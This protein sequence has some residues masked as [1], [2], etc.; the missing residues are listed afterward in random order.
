MIELANYSDL[1]EIAKLAVKARNHMLHGGLKQ[2]TGDYPNVD[3]FLN[4]YHRQGLYIYKE[5]GRIIASISI[6]HENEEAYREISWLKNHSLV[7]HRVL[8]DPE[9]QKQGI[10]LELFN[11]AKAIGVKNKYSSIKVDTHPDNFKMQGLIRKAGYKEI[12]Y[13]SNINRLAYEL[14]L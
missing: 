11:F 9:H 8:V 6:L 10:G 5:D 4:D 12:G 3:V 1:E 14:V 13:L 7:I 2:W